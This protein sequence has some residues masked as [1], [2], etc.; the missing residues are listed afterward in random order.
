MCPVVQLNMVPGGGEQLDVLVSG[1]NRCDMP[2]VGRRKR[3]KEREGG[4]ERERGGE[5]ERGR[6]EREG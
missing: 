2:G 3:E 4:K 5:R 6:G 1:C